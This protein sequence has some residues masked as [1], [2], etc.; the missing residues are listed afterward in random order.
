[1]KAIMFGTLTIA[2]A[3]ATVTT[4]SG[5][6]APTASQSQFDATDLVSRGYIYRGTGRRQ[7]L[8]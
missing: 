3:A 6:I 8:S 1:M 7:I 4:L 2:I 5:A